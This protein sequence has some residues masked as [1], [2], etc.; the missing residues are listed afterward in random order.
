M[1]RGAAALRL[2][3]AR[4]H[5]KP[6]LAVNI[7]LCLRG[8]RPSLALIV[9]RA[10]WT[11]RGGLRD[12]SRWPVA[13]LGRQASRTL[14]PQEQRGG[15][16]IGCRFER[17]AFGLR[18]PQR[19]L[20]IVDTGRLFR[21]SRHYQRHGSAPTAN[22]STQYDKAELSMHSARRFALLATSTRVDDMSQKGRTATTRPHRSL[23][24]EGMWHLRRQSH[25]ILHLKLQNRP[26]EMLNHRKP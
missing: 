15:V 25:R 5:P 3:P 11:H 19:A 17:C 22:N 23:A 21:A 20:A 13:R 4:T 18:I 1:R 12:G 2:R 8:V 6:G 14:G 26:A 24:R 16:C 10:L 7:T 9:C